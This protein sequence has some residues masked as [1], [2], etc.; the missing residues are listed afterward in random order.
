MYQLSTDI[1]PAHSFDR[2]EKLQSG[3]IAEIEIDLLAMFLHLKNANTLVVDQIQ[4][5]PCLTQNK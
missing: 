1:T 3:E 5:A 4:T 2:I